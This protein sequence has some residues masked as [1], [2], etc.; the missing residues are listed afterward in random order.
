M[1]RLKKALENHKKG[2]NCSQSVACAFCDEVGLD[3]KTIFTLMEGFGL[4]MGDMQGTCGALSGAV[5]ILSMKCSGGDIQNPTTKSST[6]KKIKEL[7]AKFKEKNST[8]I[9]EE[10]KGIKNNKIPLRSCQGCIEDA[11]IILEEMLDTIRN[12]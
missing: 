11:V 1:N 4:G 8:E 10:L 9:C 2:Y 12:S 5:A 6:Y 7:K 3:E